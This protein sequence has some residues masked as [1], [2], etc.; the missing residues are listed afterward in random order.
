[1]HLVFSAGGTGGHI[2]PALAVANEIK[3]I[4]PDADILFIGAKGKMEMERIPKAGYPIKGLW[5]S[6]FL[7]KS[8]FS[9]ISTGI[10][11]IHSLLTSFFILREHKP[12]AVIGFGGFAS[13]PSLMMATWL[14]IPTMI[15]EQN[16]YPGL[17]NRL[18]GKRVDKICT[19]Y[20][21]ASKYFNS[22]AIQLIGNPV[23]KDL[24]KA[25][26]R[27]EAVGHYGL[28]EGTKTVLLV[29]GSLG[30]RT[31][32]RAMK[33][34]KNEVEESG[35]QFIWQI[36]KLYNEEYG[37]CET[38][39]LTNVC[40]LPFLE[41]MDMAYEAADLVVA[42]AGALTISELALLGKATLLIPSPNVS[43]DH[44]TKNAMAL[45]RKKS[46]RIM[47]DDECELGLIKEIKK[48]IKEEK[49]MKMLSENIKKLAKADATNEIAKVVLGLVE[50]R[51]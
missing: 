46:A 45:V 10:K 42:R 37:K 32:N 21:E 20:E 25:V 14:G 51:H 12:E 4:V 41:R 38:A 35:V 49:E 5:I 3:K 27:K 2:F 7:G 24:T 26:D 33:S 11:L 22:D 18:L 29:G 47:K 9:K 13:G 50:N 44:Q 15:Q 36:G 30:A 16:S 39:K 6:G 40:A 8:V 17:T 31:F 19:A 43:E 48:I 23:R 28:K 34:L 1:M